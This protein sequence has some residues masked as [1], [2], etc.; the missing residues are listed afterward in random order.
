MYYAKKDKHKVLPE[1]LKW[2]SS[3]SFQVEAK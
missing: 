3:E 2:K 1:T